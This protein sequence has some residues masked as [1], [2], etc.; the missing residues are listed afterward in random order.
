MKLAAFRI[1]NFRS[2]V[3][4]GWNN[5]SPDNITVLIGQ[6]E[7]GK[8][9]VLESLNAFF[10]GTINDDVL[11]SDLS[12]P[13]VF[14]EFHT[15]KEEIIQVLKTLNLSEN[16]YTFLKEKTSIILKRSW[17]LTKLA[18][19][20]IA[21]EE[22]VALYN[23]ESE[24]NEKEQK[25]LQNSIVSMVDRGSRIENEILQLKRYEESSVHEYQRLQNSKADFHR[26][27]QKAKNSELKVQAQ[28]EHDKVSISLEQLKMQIEAKQKR[29]L[30]L[31]KELNEIFDIYK[32]CKTTIDSKQKLEDSLRKCDDLKEAISQTEISL[33]S[34]ISPRENRNLEQ[35]LNF[36]SQQLQNEYHQI[37]NSEK[38][39][40]I[41]N[42]IA[43][44][45]FKGL[46]YDEARQEAIKV[47][48][49]ANTYSSILQ[50]GEAFFKNVP[51]FEFFEDFSSLLP[52]RIDLD[53]LLNENTAVE[54]YKAARNFLIISGIDA[55]FFAQQNNRILKQKIEN[56]NGEITIN[57][58]DFWR[59]SI[60]K[61]NKIKINFELEHYDFSHPDK[62][63]K[64]YLE[65]WIKDTKERLYPKQRSRGVRWF[66]SFY[67]ELKAAAKLHQREKVLLIDEPGISLHAR[68]QE[69]V[70]KVFEDIKENLMIIYTT[71][72][73]H[74]VDVNKMYRILA[75]QRALEDDDTSETLV[76]DAA[77]L[78]RA[79]TDTLSPIYAMMG[80]RFTDQQFIHKHNNILVEDN[81]SYYFL[82]ALYTL[83]KPEKEMF[84]LPATS[85]KNIPTLANLLLGWKLEYL[86][87]LSDAPET[88]LVKRELFENLFGND[89]QRMT[90]KLI[91]LENQGKIVDL[92]SVIDFKNFILQKRIGITESNSEYLEINGLAPAVLSMEFMNNVSTGKFSFA[93]F[94]DE[95]KE[96][97]S[98]LFSKISG[99]L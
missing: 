32:H 54:G 5:V 38:E 57:F 86:I 63:G 20:E 91:S 71:H 88:A 29:R 51:L 26:M 2:I 37:E 61:N 76:Y 94:D 99:L 65:F 27:V 72:S 62:K 19:I 56:L 11:R 12:H 41:N 39:T 66:L 7:S 77:S 52:N 79:S 69:D 21:N 16:S 25:T 9:S 55:E 1:L 78:S 47:L 87:V 15:D 83:L 74:L 58:Q 42:S 33:N 6:N 22:I 89:N 8:T 98:R 44:C 75:I 60:G 64:P 49:N 35:K 68:A 81:A 93:D 90:N 13:S 80:A 31:Q 97:I 95:S 73:P 30:E 24:N 70:L 14:C 53:D 84:F 67:L 85:A 40:T 36:L 50:I 46:P 82:T 17:N 3:D 28:T 48:S 34:T 96:N 43:I 10:S 92:F 18:T 4:S 45:L 23:Q 59:Q